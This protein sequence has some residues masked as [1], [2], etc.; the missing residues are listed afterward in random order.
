MTMIFVRNS[1][2]SQFL[3]FFV[4]NDIFDLLNLS[5]I[6]FDILIWPPWYFTTFVYEEIL[7]MVVISDVKYIIT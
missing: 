3:I 4:E 1:K 2:I 6:I 7:V 5:S